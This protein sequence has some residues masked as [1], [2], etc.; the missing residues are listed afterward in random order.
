M[1]GILK[2]KRLFREDPEALNQFIYYEQAD[3]RAFVLGE[4]DPEEIADLNHF[5]SLECEIM[6]WA[7]DTAYC[8]NDLVNSINAGFFNRKSPTLGRMPEPPGRTSSTRRNGS[9]GH[10]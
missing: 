1:D 5:R 2:Y 3:L 6:D 10:S 7:D 4:I 8:L 9:F